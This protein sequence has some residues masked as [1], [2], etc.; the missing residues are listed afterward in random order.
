ML[1]SSTRMQVANSHVQPELA[2]PNVPFWL[3]RH[4]DI[5]IKIPGVKL[6]IDL[7]RPEGAHLALVELVDKMKVAIGLLR[8]HRNMR[9]HQRPPPVD[10]AFTIGMLNE[11]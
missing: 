5:W 2:E 1:G 11:F 7:V 3:R 4:A 10:L 8:E 9:E 6:S